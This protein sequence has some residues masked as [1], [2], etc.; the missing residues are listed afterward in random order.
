MASVDNGAQSETKDQATT[1]TTAA[2]DPYNVEA[3][4][5]L[6]SSAQHM[7]IAQAAPIYEQILSLF[8]TAVSVFF[9]LT[10]FSFGL[11]FYIFYFL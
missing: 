1:S 7:P 8:P 9:F 10:F 4:E 3:A 5:I 11:Y 6:A 2:T